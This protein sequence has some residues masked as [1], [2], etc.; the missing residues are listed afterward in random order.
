MLRRLSEFFLCLL[1][2][3]CF[4]P[5]CANAQDSLVK[6]TMPAF[7]HA[8]FFYDLPLSFGSFTGIDFPIK[9][10]VFISVDRAGK[11]EIKYRDAI[12]ASDIGFYR[13]DFNNTGLYFFESIGKRYYRQR[14]YYFEWMITVGFLRT[15]YDGIVYAV[16]DNGNVKQLHNYGKY[17]A[18]TGGTAVFGHDFLK[19]KKPKPFAIDIRPSLW[20]QYP[21]NS[22]VLPHLSASLT[23][24]YHFQ[25]MNITIKQKRIT[26]LVN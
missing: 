8:S 3:I 23:F 15:F 25:G 10:K 12:V 11:K 26:N 24:K 7:L 20:F 14:P 22:F 18:V 6:V 19:A 2:A 5:F 4:T 21:Y 16:D 1:I 9:S 13:Y 17:Y